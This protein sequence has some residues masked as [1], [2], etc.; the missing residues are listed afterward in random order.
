MYPSAPC[1]LQFGFKLSR[2]WHCPGCIIP[3][4]AI[5]GNRQYLFSLGGSGVFTSDL[6]LR[7]TC[8]KTQKLEKPVVSSHLSHPDKTITARKVTYHTYHHYLPEGNFHQASVGAGR[9]SW[10]QTELKARKKMLLRSAQIV[11]VVTRIGC[12]GQP[13]ETSRLLPPR[14]SY[15]RRQ[16]IHVLISLDS[17]AGTGGSR[18][19]S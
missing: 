18:R 2:F 3:A 5:C 4:L 9:L 8:L 12:T 15:L 13:T 1:L 17:L 10:S 7:G 6:K 14:W 19:R 11:L 16:K